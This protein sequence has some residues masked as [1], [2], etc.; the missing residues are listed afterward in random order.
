MR[1]EFKLKSKYFIIFYSIIGLIP[2][3]SSEILSLLSK[4][5][6]HQ[7]ELLDQ[8]SILYGALIVSF[9]CGMH[10]EKLIYLRK[11]NLYFLPM[12]I[13]VVVWS[14]HFFLIEI[15]KKYIIILSLI[16]CLIMDLLVLN[17]NRALWFKKT[18]VFVTFLAVSSYII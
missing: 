6:V 15:Y 10:W 7:N 9:L 13:V 5:T 18:R 16:L 4:L 17:K 12:I 8:S 1:Q 11:Y 2:F 3:F 14:H